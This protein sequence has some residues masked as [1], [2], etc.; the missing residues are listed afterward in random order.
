MDNHHH[1]EH[2]HSHSH[3]LPKNRLILA[4]IITSVILIAEFTGAMISNSLALLADS[5]HMLTDLAALIF[6]WLGF[7]LG[8]KKANSRKTFGYKRSE[9]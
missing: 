7:R 1:H 2:G 8:E 6:S 4:I 3:D 9:I 5:G